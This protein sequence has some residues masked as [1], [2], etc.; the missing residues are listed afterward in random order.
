MVSIAG[1]VERAALLAELLM[2][3]VARSA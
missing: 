1:M 3:P 2:L